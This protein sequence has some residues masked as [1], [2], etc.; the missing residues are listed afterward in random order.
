M[1]ELVATSPFAGLA[2]PR[3]AG[4]ATLAA[5]PELPR[6]SVATFAGVPPIA[7]LP[8]PGASADR[9]G[10]RLLWAG[11]DLW[12]AEGAG[13]AAFAATATRAGAAVTD[14]S[15]AWAGLALAGDA[16][17]DVLAR[18]VPIDAAPAAFAPGA[19]AR[20]LLR[21][22]PCLLAAVPGG[23][24]IRIPRS[25]AATAFHELAEAMDSVA[26]RA[27]I[28]GRGRFPDLLGT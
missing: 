19:T 5:L 22:I 28:D 7:G 17:A 16:T 1:T 24:E 20:T 2:L 13:A 15:D 10:V 23:V 8:D 11:L 21:H 25:Y 6:F 4:A 27:E 26:A 9:D 12:L 14:Q 18:L 3:A